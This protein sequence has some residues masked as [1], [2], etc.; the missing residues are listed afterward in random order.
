[1]TA[2]TWRELNWLHT[3]SCVRFLT[4]KCPKVI[5]SHIR[6]PYCVYVG[7]RMCASIYV[8][9]SICVR[10]CVYVY[11]CVTASTRWELNWLHTLSCV[12]R[13][14][15]AIFVSLIVRDCSSIPS[16]KIFHS[17]QT[18]ESGFLWSHTETLGWPP[19]EYTSK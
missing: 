3:L 16:T 14:S 17:F 7:A 12:R 18:Y 19:D 11:L 5:S 2:F 1:M 8:C 4:D 9:V 10:D 13:W 6:E 15:P